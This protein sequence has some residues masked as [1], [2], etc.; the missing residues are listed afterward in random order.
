[1]NLA[2][3]GAGVA[4]LAAAQ[5]LRSRRPEIDIT[6]YEKSR[7]VGGRAATRRVEGYSFDHGAQY[8]K[9]PTP[10]IEQLYT[11]DLA[12]QEPVDI[13][14]PVWI[15]DGTG[16]IGEG[17]PA[18][19]A[20]PKWT[21]RS[22]ISALGKGLARGLT[23]RTEVRVA[24]LVPL[25]AG[26]YTLHDADGAV[27]GQADAVLLTPPGPQTAEIIAASPLDA[28]LKAG[29]LEALRPATYR[30]CLSL[31]FAYAVRP[32]LPWYAMVN[33]D[34]QHP[35]SWLAAEHAKPGRAP[36]NM[37]LL[38]AQMAP[39]WSTLHYDEAQAGTFAQVADAPAF[40]QEAERLVQ[41]L[42]GQSLGQPLWANLQRWRYALPDGHADGDV[43]NGTGS[44]LFF[45]G[46]YTAD[47]GRIHLAIEEGWKVAERIASVDG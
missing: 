8:A 16:Q 42:V 38:T 28:T 31:T 22:G 41:A 46:D 33:I 9:A 40:V 43:L 7:G 25:A 4:G 1:M 2:I 14:L 47:L 5:A 11:T 36:S 23:V 24:T 12:A 6:I 35:V 26:G 13:G 17:D 18:Q 19:N 34:R 29:L 27:L 3:I 44:G 32:A 15:F 45:A 20:D 37:G 39:G 10:A 30:R 21:F